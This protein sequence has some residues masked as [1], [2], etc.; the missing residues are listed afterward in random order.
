[1]PLHFE[2]EV[3]CLILFTEIFS[4]VA[5]RF[6]ALIP[7]LVHL[8]LLKR[9]GRVCGCVSRAQSKNPRFVLEMRG[10]L[11][12]NQNVIMFLF[13]IQ[14][15]AFSGHEGRVGTPVDGATAFCLYFPLW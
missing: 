5:A 12:R 10:V 6:A 8:F 11:F 14:A 7:T 13:S 2:G 1:M 9:W 3:C 4:D 15:I